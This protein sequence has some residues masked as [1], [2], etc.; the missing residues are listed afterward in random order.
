MPTINWKKSDKNTN[1][2]Y[3]P[4]WPPVNIEFQDLSYSVP[5]QSGKNVI[6]NGI[7]GQF[8]SSQIS[9]I[10]GASGAGKSTLLNILAGFKTSKTS[11]NVLIN[12]KP[13]CIRTFRKMSRYIM[14]KDLHHHHLT[15][16]EAMMVSADLKLGNHL[17]K[18]QKNEVIQQILDLLG[19]TNTSQTMC[20]VLS[21][22]EMKRLSIA[23]E[24]V[25]NPPVIFLDE[26]TTGLDDLSSSQCISLLRRIALGGRTIVC[27][28]H[29][30][31]AKIL[32]MFDLVYAMAGGQC[33]Y[34]G[35]PSQIIPYL[36]TTG[37]TCP[38]TYN[39]ADFIVEVSCGDCG[40]EYID[41]MVSA[42]EN[43]K[44]NSWSL[45]LANQNVLRKKGRDKP[46][47]KIPEDIDPKQLK[48]RSS[49]WDQFKVL[50]NR[51]WKQMSRESLSLPFK[52]CVSLCTA[53]L[54]GCLFQGCGNDAS[55]AMFNVQYS[56]TV[57]I[58][59]IYAPLMMVLVYFPGEIA[60]LK[61]EHFNRWF[62]L[63]PY[64]WAFLLATAPVHI[65]ICL[66]FLTVTYPMTDQPLEWT[67]ICMFF[68]ITIMIAL[69]SER[70]GLLIASRFNLVNGLF[71]GPAV[72]FPI[73]LLSVCGMG[74]GYKFE[75]SPFLKFLRNFS[76]LR[77]ALEGLFDA[78]YGHNRA[79]TVCPDIEMFCLFAK[80][81]YLKSLLG[82]HESSYLVSI[83]ALW[84]YYLLFA[85]MAYFMIKMRLSLFTPT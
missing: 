28:I 25:D 54:V 68:S 49:S 23:L 34:Q 1:L 46:P 71:I 24:L 69:V 72:M 21:G 53:V 40:I 62:K 6:L 67:R 56:F 35:S 50:H 4:Q 58:L 85:T 57:T 26:P 29:I 47:V 83:V 33:V 65:V 27:S 75:I 76:Y 77:F 79:D 20:E 61:R 15:V 48:C 10:L 31:S 42:A 82:F 8:Q 37:L 41:R 80:A 36:Q 17:T 70:M 52:F 81:D 59:F 55:K 64:Y 18:L 39:P 43:G 13:R 5:H 9:A 32:E 14:Q 44:C 16:H 78:T 66:T 3:I 12:G 22:G 45:H 84:S 60:L 19:L 74:D 51:R 73:V 63:A 30:P 11:V 2:K 38:I 7:S